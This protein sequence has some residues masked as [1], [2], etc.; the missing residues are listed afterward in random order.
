MVSLRDLEFN[1]ASW[2]SLWADVK[3]LG[4]AAYVMLS[5][6]FDEY[7]FNRAGFLECSDAKAA[8]LTAEKA[9]EAAWRAPCFSVP[10]ECGGVVQTLESHGYDAFDRMSVMRLGEPGFRVASGLSV[11]SGEEV[12][13]SDWATAYSLSFY[14]DLGV[15]DSVTR[16]VKRLGR[17]PAVTL[18]AG[19]K[20]GGLAGVLAAFRTPGLLGVYCV[21]TLEKHRRSGVAG[22][23]LAEVSRMAASEA[24]VMILQTI[25]SDRVG[26]FYLDGGFSEIYSKLLMSRG[27]PG[28]EKKRSAR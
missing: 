23:L 19:E 16:I 25:V 28:P 1:E 6:D 20:G 21:G 18:L 17:D 27:R 11:N 26:N 4:S 3:W 12:D 8:I 7:F 10:E 5:S 9:F 14:G 24:R 22:S 15:K 13:V 2:W